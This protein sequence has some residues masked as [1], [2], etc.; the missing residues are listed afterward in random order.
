MNQQFYHKQDF[1]PFLKKKKVTGHDLRF[2]IHF[3]WTKIQEFAV[4]VYTPL[5][6][7]DLCVVVVVLLL[8]L[9]QDFFLKEL[10]GG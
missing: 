3:G 1:F 9:D 8:V 5:T 10:G 4:G 7:R 2:Y 6:V